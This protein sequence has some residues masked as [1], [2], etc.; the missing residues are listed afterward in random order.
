MHDAYDSAE[1][2]DLGTLPSGSPFTV[3]RYAVQV[4]LLLAEGFI[5]PHFFAGFSGGG[6]SVLS[7]ICDKIIILNNHCGQFIT[8]P[9]ARPGIL[10]HNPI[11]ID[12]TAAVRMVHLVYITNV[13]IDEQRATVATFAGDFGQAHLAGVKFLRPYCQVDAVPGN[14]AITSNGGRP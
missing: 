2:V 9:H 12:M 11:H 14:I 7:G 3:S 8:S 10:E 1:H 6:K 13:V 4:G 5:E